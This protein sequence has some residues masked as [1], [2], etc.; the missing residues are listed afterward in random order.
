V[1]ENEGSDMHDL[2]Y[3]ARSKVT[4]QD[5]GRLCSAQR[6][7]RRHAKSPAIRGGGTARPRRKVRPLIGAPILPLLIVWPALLLF[8]SG[9]SGDA[10]VELRAADA[11]DA[12]ATQMDTAA[13]EYHAEIERYDASRRAAV[14]AAY[15]ERI[16]RDAAD[17]DRCANHTSDF[18][19]ALDRIDADRGTELARASAV[20]SQVAAVRE[21][22]RGLRRL[23]I[24][25][26]S[27]QDEMRRY[28]TSLAD[29][30][31]AAKTASAA[32]PRSAASAP[33]LPGRVSNLIAPAFSR[34]KPATS[35]TSDSGDECPLTEMAKR[36]LGR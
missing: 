33:A 4:G 5:A 17:K 9:C 6:R 28:F 12:V 20:A 21:V 11:L 36:S 30:Y 18:L 7:A 24:E 22:S 19:L 29:N 34:V 2:Q 8:G 15:V 13:S 35:G 31:R 32:A 23:A 1:A 14:A 10:S 3:A 25:S 26:L 27:L 16:A